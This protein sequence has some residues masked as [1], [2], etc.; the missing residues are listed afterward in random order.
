MH[1]LTIRNIEDP[2]KERLRMSAA[3]HG[4]SMEEEVRTIL[5]KVLTQAAPTQ[6]LGSRVHARFAAVGGIELALP[7]RNEPARAAQWDVPGQTEQR[8]A[9]PTKPSPTSRPARSAAKSTRSAAARKS[10]KA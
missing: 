2:I 8:K 3:L 1:T 10:G 7:T 4:R 9:A 6:G 5:R